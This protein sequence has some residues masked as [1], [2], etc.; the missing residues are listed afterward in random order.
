MTIARSLDAPPPVFAT[1]LATPLGQSLDADAAEWRIDRTH[2]T[3]YATHV[4]LMNGRAELRVALVGG[5]VFEEDWHAR[6]LPEEVSAAALEERLD[7]LASKLSG[8]VDDI[9][10][11]FDG[12]NASSSSASRSGSHALWPVSVRPLLGQIEED[13]GEL[14]KRLRETASVAGEVADDLA[15]RGRSS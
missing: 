4:V 3:A 10:T 7:T 13:V 2:V 5:R 15:E 6:V 8:V 12:M 14:E 11:L 9:Q 1:L